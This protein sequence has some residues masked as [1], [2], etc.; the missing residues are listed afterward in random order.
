MGRTN[1]K[2]GKEAK[3]ISYKR[4]TLKKQRANDKAQKTLEVSSG[5]KPQAP[6]T[7]L[8]ANATQSQIKRVIE[9]V[10]RL[11]ESP[12]APTIVP[13]VSFFNAALVQ[14]TLSALSRPPIGLLERAVV[15]NFNPDESKM[16]G[17]ATTEH[18]PNEDGRSE[19]FFHLHGG[20]D[21]TLNPAHPT[22]EF[23][24]TF[25]SR[26]DA[27]FR[28]PEV[29]DG[30]VFIRGRGAKGEKI[31]KWGYEKELLTVL[32]SVQ[33]PPHYRMIRVVHPNSGKGSKTVLWLGTSIT[34]LRKHFPLE[35]RQKGQRPVVAGVTMTSEGTTR[36]YFEK[37]DTEF[38]PLTGLGSHPDGEWVP[39][40]DPRKK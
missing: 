30:I 22:T 2:G 23:R 1:R 29:G 38:N 27:P 25:R 8:P 26:T 19:L 40:D 7:P 33:N 4:D 17:F 34:D 31:V 12:K 10:D 6:I 13:T 20:C 39:C 28:H 9:Q 14:S 3:T 32:D 24:M 35:T 18:Q 21:F 11:G 5:K 37:L 16:F 36:V 15:R